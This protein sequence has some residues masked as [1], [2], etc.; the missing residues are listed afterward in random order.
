M[1][2]DPSRTVKRRRKA[3]IIWDDDIEAAPYM[4]IKTIDTIDIK[5]GKKI[6]QH[7]EVPLYASG[8]QLDANGPESDLSIRMDPMEEFGGDIP[9]FDDVPAEL[10][11]PRKVNRQLFH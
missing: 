7:V 1:S 11:R 8:S 5:T 4:R 3:K 2:G 6:I 10:P 9:L